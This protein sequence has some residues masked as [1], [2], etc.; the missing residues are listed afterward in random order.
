MNRWVR[1]A[2]A[3]GVA[4][5]ASAL[6]P[7]VSDAAPAPWVSSQAAI[8][9]GA[10]GSGVSS[11]NSGNSQALTWNPFFIAGSTGQA[12]VLVP[13][14]L[15]ITVTVNGAVVYSVDAMKASAPGATTCSLSGGSDGVVIS[16]TVVGNVRTT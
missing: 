4:S 16:G 9:C 10:A 13:T 1:I 12:A 2:A 7:G 11:V 5:G 6:W 14:T 8:D 3:V 15:Q